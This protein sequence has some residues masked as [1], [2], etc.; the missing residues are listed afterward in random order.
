MATSQ[1]S[2]PS[3]VETE[4]VTSIQMSTS[5]PSSTQTSSLPITQISTQQSTSSTE[6]G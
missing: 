3:T 1:S 4:I 2:T 5:Q 6:E